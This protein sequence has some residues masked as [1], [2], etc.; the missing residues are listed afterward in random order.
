M[1]TAVDTNVFIA[2]WYKDDALNTLARSAMDAAIARGSLVISAPVFAELQASPTRT[3]AF[4]EYFLKEAGIA[5]DWE[6]EEQT[7][8]TAGRAFQAY[9]RRRKRH[10]DSGPR[11]ILADFLIG[12]H[13]LRRGYHLLTLDDRIYSSAFPRLSILSV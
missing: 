5:V 1:T 10:G 12:A 7:W 8:R 2:L 3:E 11:R 9:A 6:I 4:V 13:A